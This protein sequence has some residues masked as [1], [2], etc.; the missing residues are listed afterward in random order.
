MHGIERVQDHRL[1][2]YAD[3][4]LFPGRITFRMSDIECTA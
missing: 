1:G 3:I 2:F 4:D